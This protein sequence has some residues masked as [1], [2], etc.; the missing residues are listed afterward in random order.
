MV[1]DILQNSQF[2]LMSGAWMESGNIII[3]LTPDALTKVQ[4]FFYVRL[5]PGQHRFSI[6]ASD[7]HKT[8]GKRDT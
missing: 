5:D 7:F 2:S 4:A 6:F 3:T 8:P 1:L